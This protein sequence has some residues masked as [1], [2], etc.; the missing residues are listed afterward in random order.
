[1]PKKKIQKALAAR[2]SLRDV[3]AYLLDRADQYEDGSSCWVALAEVARNVMRGEIAA[4][5]RNGDFD[6]ALY[7]R[8]DSPASRL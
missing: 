3:A 5:K 4:A 7:A 2:A 1:M 8:V 6:A